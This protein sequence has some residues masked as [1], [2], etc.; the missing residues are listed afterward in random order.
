MK[1]RTHDKQNEHKVTLYPELVI[2]HHWRVTMSNDADPRYDFI[3][4]GERKRPKRVPGREVL[5]RFLACRTPED[6]LQFFRD[7]GPFEI[8]AKPDGAVSVAQRRDS[9]YIQMK[10]TEND[11]K[12]E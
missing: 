1:R 6:M 8:N 4:L 9:G 11:D 10:P 3:C 5:E 2:T 12:K 7:F